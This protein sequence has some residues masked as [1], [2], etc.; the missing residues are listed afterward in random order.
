MKNK[1]SDVLKKLFLSSLAGIAANSTV[2]AAAVIDAPGSI[3]KENEFSIIKEKD[4]S[5]KLLLKLNNNSGWSLISHRSHRSHSS[6]RSHYSGASSSS[7]SGSTSS[8]SSSSRSS[9]STS[10]TSGS[11]TTRPLGFSSSGSSSG[12]GSSKQTSSSTNKNSP[13]KTIAGLSATALK[14]GDRNLK[15]D[16]SGSDVT[17]LIN[18]LLKKGYLLLENGQ[19][20]VYG[21]YT[22][23]ETIEATVKKYQKDNNLTGS[24]NCDAST[25][26]HLLNK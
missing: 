26:Y 6:H 21:T 19:N 17:E 14:L 10:S 23:D 9:S 4:L 7:S 25:A 11:S 8:G 13:T 15:R 12:S 22:Y 20:Q 18:I 3:Y 24:G 16:M 2:Q 1:L 5:P